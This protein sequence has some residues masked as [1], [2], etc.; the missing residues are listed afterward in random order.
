MGSGANP[1]ISKI[2]ILSIAIPCITKAPFSP[3]RWPTLR[4]TGY[5]VVWSGLCLQQV[6]QLRW[7]SQN[8]PWPRLGENWGDQWFSTGGPWDQ[9]LPH[10][11]GTSKLLTS[12]GPTPNLLH[13]NLWGV[14]PS[15]LCSITCRW[16]WCMLGKFETHWVEP[17]SSDSWCVF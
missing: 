4:P 17:N 5:A 6:G 15:S 1:F 13:Q 9:R 3:V 2:P 16:F 12:L 11:V 10:H 7:E 8:L 14:W